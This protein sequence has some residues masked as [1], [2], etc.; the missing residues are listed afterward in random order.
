MQVDDVQRLFYDREFRHAFLTKKGEEF[1]AWFEE[2]AGRAYG[3][4]FEAVR[5][6][7]RQG[8]RKC[9]GR[10]V[11][12]GTIFQVYAPD[13]MVAATVEAKIKADFHGAADHWP[14]MRKWVF[15]MNQERGLPP[16]TVRLL[17][18]LRDASPNV[19]IEVWGQTELRRLTH[20]FSLWDWQEVFGDVPGPRRMGCTC[21]PRYQGGS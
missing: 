5:S 15:V 6:Y 12:N 10:Q 19:A 7:G 17:D 16:S 13:H 14:N 4:D 21:D 20:E 3:P 9:D 8:D 1:Q 11:S 2:L 18:Q